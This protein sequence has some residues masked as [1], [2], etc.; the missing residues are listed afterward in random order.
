QVRLADGHTR[1]VL[2]R[3]SE[4][5]V[6]TRALS[7]AERGE[8]ANALVAR[9]AAR[10]MSA[11]DEAEIAPARHAATATRGGGMGMPAAAAPM[12]NNISDGVT[13]RVRARAVDMGVAY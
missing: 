11:A 2:Q 4:R 6:T 3:G 5:F 8:D 1:V 12:S 9:G 7:D 10:R 13:R